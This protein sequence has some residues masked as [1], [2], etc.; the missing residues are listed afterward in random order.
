MQPA[1]PQRPQRRPDV[2]ELAS[3]RAVLAGFVES[4]SMPRLMEVATKPPPAVAYR[5]EF[6]RDARGRPRMAG[7]VEGTWPL[8]C[9]RC[10]GDLDWRFDVKFKTLVLDSEDGETVD[11]D[12]VVC[13]GGR[14]SLEPVIED[15]LLLALPNAPVHPHGSCEAPP[16]RTDGGRTGSGRTA[17]GEE[18]GRRSNPFSVLRTLRPAQ[19]ADRSESI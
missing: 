15:E 8:V 3:R 6:T 18:P 17:D 9:Q 14:I 10:L 16:I 13:P 2:E 1:I 4:A 12:V 7:R 19:G 11:Q 5:I